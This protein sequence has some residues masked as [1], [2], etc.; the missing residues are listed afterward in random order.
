MNLSKLFYECN[1]LKEV[2]FPSL[3]N[4]QITNMSRM[5][6]KCS[7]L[8]KIT[9]SPLFTT[10]KVLDMPYMFSKCEN[11][12][13]LNYEQ[14]NTENVMEKLDLNNFKLEMLKICHIC[15]MAA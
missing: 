10:K 4:N 12:K 15:F 3:I 9:F 13:D 7:L 1:Y 5:F 2:N 11:L 14:F 6:E 8:E